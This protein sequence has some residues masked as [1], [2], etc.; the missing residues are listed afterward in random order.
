MS[1]KLLVL[2]RHG[3]A[4]S[5]SCKL[6]GNDLLRELT[7]LGITK[8]NR[9][10]KFLYNK[11]INFD[12]IISSNSIRTNQTAQI[13]A[14]GLNYDINEIEYKESLYNGNF[15][16][17]VSMMDNIDKKINKLMVVGHSP[18]ITEFG[19]YLVGKPIGHLQPGGIICINLGYIDWSNFHKRE[20]K[21]MFAKNFLQ[22]TLKLA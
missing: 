4:E 17:Y 5:L 10:C 3:D 14:Q 16:N 22:G 18:I 11:N 21:L 8:I 2:I 20:A 12:K 15:D 19:E 1:E 6:P 9:L 7:S 13:I